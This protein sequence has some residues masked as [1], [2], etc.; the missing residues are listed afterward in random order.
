[1]SLMEISFIW[2]IFS[3]TS[4]III[5][6]YIYIISRVKWIRTWSIG[7]AFYLVCQVIMFNVLSTNNFSIA[8][9]IRQI[10]MIMSS[11]FFLRGTRESFNLTEERKWNKICPFCIFWIIIS[12][13]TR[14]PLIIQIAPIQI[15]IGIMFINIG[16]TT[17]K[18][19]MREDK[20]H[21]IVGWSFIIWGLHKFDYIFLYR[22]TKV[23]PWG[24][25]FTTVLQ[26]TIVVSI[27]LLYFYNMK[28][29]LENKE[30]EYK[31]SERRVCNMA[32]YDSLTELPNK[33]YLNSYLTEVVSKAKVE[34]NIIAVLF[35]D[36]DKFKNINDNLG[37]VI[38]DKLLK[39]IAVKLKRLLGDE[40]FIARLG[41]DEFIIV[42]EELKDKDHA[43][44]IAKKIITEFKYPIT[45]EGYELFST[46]SIGVSMFPFDGEDSEA[47]IKS[48]DIAMYRAKDSGRDNYQFFTKEMK[49]TLFNA[50]N[51]ANSLRHAIKR[52]ELEVQYQ[53][54]IDINTG[55][56][57]GVEALLRWN[58]PILG[59]ISP[60]DFIPIA[61]ETGLIL[62]IGQWILSKACKQNKTWHEAGFENISMAVNISA[63]QL[64]QPD[65]YEIVEEILRET[66]LDPHY[67]ELEITE[68]IAIRNI[69][70]INKVLIRFRELGVNIAMDDF[71]T[72][73]SALSCLNQLTLDILKIDQS[74]IRNL[75]DNP[76][77]EEI[78]AAIIKMAHSLGLKVTAEGVE[79]YNDLEF[80]KNNNCDF[81]Q[82][83]YFSK[84]VPAK[85]LEN[86]LMKQEVS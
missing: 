45:I 81:F 73:Y 46:V 26:Y 22:V 27:I 28:K 11:I 77:N 35:L 57:I 49:R 83:Y 38:G 15:V 39:E 84:P 29:Q 40:G 6:L 79:E 9:I 31:E 61:E 76:R 68:S 30:L 42:F 62:P 86:L 36:F 12:A 67:L 18:C 25:F 75:K 32:Y 3:T 1:M 47:L 24:Y 21:F 2:T 56:I 5:Y 64:Q 44:E 51:L 60:I 50:F 10:F 53:P 13:I 17:V 80:L 69:T 55:N 78:A 82:G 33:V 65:F 70:K 72:G 19:K 74:F 14:M 37:H 58:H 52:D 71:G 66:R 48:A 23:A 16:I 34:N 20:L 63:R 8:H 7:W 43:K 54:K 4:I 59:Y 85:D 41:G